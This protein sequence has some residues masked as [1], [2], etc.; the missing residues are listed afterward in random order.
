MET[1]DYL[2]N[3]HLIEILS[4]KPKYKIPEEI[5]NKMNNFCK[6][7]EVVLQ[8]YCEVTKFEATDYDK[9]IYWFL[10]HDLDL[11]LETIYVSGSNKFSKNFLLD[12]IKVVAF[13]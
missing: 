8:K 3:K 1:F 11:N 12:L 6:D 13:K 2:N 4:S 7:V 9:K 10:Y 5:L